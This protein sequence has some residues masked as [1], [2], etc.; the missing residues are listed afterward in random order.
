MKNRFRLLV[1]WCVLGASLGACASVSHPPLATVDSVDLPRFMGT[2]YVVASIPT[3]LERGAHN[4]VEHYELQEDGTVTTTFTF[5]AGGFDGPQRRYR[6]RGF[7]QDHRS[8]AVWGMQFVWPIRADF[9][10]TWLS[11][12]YGITAVARE[13]RD[14]VWVMARN[15][16]IDPESMNR[17]RDHLAAQGYDVERIEPVPQRW[18]P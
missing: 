7:V 4:A 8:N 3:W 2:W 11:E 14:Y 13:R 15:P 1:S 9:R 16:Q 12:D 10:I 5:R 18:M 17:I 6:A